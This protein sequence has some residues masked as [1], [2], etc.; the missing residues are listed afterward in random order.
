MSKSGIQPL[1]ALRTVV[2]RLIP[3]PLFWTALLSYAA[4]V[5]L[6]L[7]LNPQFIPTD[8]NGGPVRLGLVLLLGL[9]NYAEARIALKHPR[10]GRRMES[11]AWAVR[12]SMAA[13]VLALVPYGL[14][15]LQKLVDE[16]DVSSQTAPAVAV[17]VAILGFWG[18]CTV[19]RV[20]VRSAASKAPRP[21]KSAKKRSTTHI[22]MT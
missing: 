10:S 16:G 19:G 12:A 5:G 21:G 20:W 1:T 8:A 11:A 18:Y 6:A 14:D 15:E 9:A 13:V 3:T 2:R 4:A 17:I 22:L 7:S